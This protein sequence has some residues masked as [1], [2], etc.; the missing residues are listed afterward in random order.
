M[1]AEESLTGVGTNVPRTGVLGPFGLEHPYWVLPS[2]RC[3]SV[4]TPLDPADEEFSRFLI[5]K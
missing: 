1:L 3:T 4:G 2:P 5:G